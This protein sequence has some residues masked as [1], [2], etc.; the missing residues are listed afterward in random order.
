MTGVFVALSKV[1]RH[2]L[3]MTD[4][5][6][7]ALSDKHPQ[8][9]GDEPRLGGAAAIPHLFA[10]VADNHLRKRWEAVF[11][12]EAFGEQIIPG[13]LALLNSERSG[14][15]AAGVWLL[16]KVGGD[17]EVGAIAHHLE[18]DGD[19]MPGVPNNNTVGD[20]AREALQRI[21]SQAA[22]ERLRNASQG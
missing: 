3:P 12:L 20:L 2:D 17:A 1:A 13:A 7:P 16:G 4:E 22:L 19:A 5:Q 15:R 21:E 14:V 6:S 11:E 10:V 18:D 8:L 9:S